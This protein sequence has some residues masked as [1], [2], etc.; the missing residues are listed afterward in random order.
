MRSPPPES[1]SNKG[2]I[3]EQDKLNVEEMPE[4]HYCQEC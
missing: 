1:M 2:E 4:Q 3:D